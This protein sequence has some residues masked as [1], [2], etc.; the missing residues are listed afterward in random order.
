MK[1]LVLCLVLTTCLF[2]AN[3]AHAAAPAND[4]ISAAESIDLTQHSIVGGSMRETTVEPGEPLDCAPPRAGAEAFGTIWY[5]LRPAADMTVGL[6]P[7]I[8]SPQVVPHPALIGVGLYRRTSGALSLVACADRAFTRIPLHGQSDYFLQ[9]SASCAPG[10]YDR[11]QVDVAAVPAND[12]VQS[13]KEIPELPFGD[14][15]HL[16]FAGMG[17]DEPTGCVSSAAW[18]RATDEPQA[19]WYRF[20]ATHDDV[21]VGY[22]ERG[23]GAPEGGIFEMTPA[24]AVTIACAA[25]DVDIS[26]GLDVATFMAPV[27]ASTTY[28]VEMH[29]YDRGTYP[30]FIALASVP[31]VDLAIETVAVT[32][33]GA[34]RAVRVDVSPEARG[35]FRY[36]ITACPVTHPS[37]CSAIEAGVHRFGELVADWNTVG[38]MGD[39]VVKA[40][41]SAWYDVDPDSSNNEGEVSVSLDAGGHGAGAGLCDAVWPLE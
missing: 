5:V 12:S 10:C 19:V 3:V 9:I 21:V 32:G 24:G 1:A 33:E 2:G 17:P 6:H 23:L 15:Q 18:Q 34:T 7:T 29:A 28:L 35:G 11:P 41:I 20:T 40:T 39:V 25:V 22:L 26:S 38:C 36:E 4:N 13:A 8:G 31:R 27:K 14:G 30:S 16:Q 37:A